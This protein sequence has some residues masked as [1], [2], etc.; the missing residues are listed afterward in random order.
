MPDAQ[1]GQVENLSQSV[2]TVEGTSGNDTYAAS[3]QT[4]GSIV[5]HGGAGND[6]LAG[7]GGNDTFKYVV[8]DGADVIDG[9]AGS[10]TLDYTGTASAV[11]VDLG[12]GT[13]TGIGVTGITNIQNVIGGSA[14]DTLTGGA[15][16]NK[17][18]GGGGNDTITG[19]GGNDTAV[20]TTTLALAGPHFQ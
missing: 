14:G 12:A 10:N 16:A 6:T 18:T 7:G 9:G 20:Y 11:T 17:F 5:F 2:M 19:G 15:G 8:G 4:T 1:N 3:A 13:A